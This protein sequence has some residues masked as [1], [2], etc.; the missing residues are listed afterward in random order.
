MILPK[1]RHH[2][3]YLLVQNKTLEALS[4]NCKDSFTHLYRKY[5]YIVQLN[6]CDFVSLPFGAVPDYVH[7]RFPSSCLMNWFKCVFFFLQRN[8]VLHNLWDFVGV[9]ISD[10]LKVKYQVSIAD[11]V[12]HLGTGVPIFAMTSKRPGVWHVP[13]GRRQPYHSPNPVRRF[14]SQ[15]Y[16][17]ELNI[18]FQT[19]EVQSI[20][21]FGYR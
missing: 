13:Y 20:S 2:I 17:I 12:G 19:N 3:R 5:L 4:V 14:I 11:V 16:L 8:E 1:F 9:E 21:S 18:R 10:N 15:V 6:K 7:Q